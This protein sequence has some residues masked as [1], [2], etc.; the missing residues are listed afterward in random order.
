MNELTRRDFVRG[1]WTAGVGIG[2]A[3]ELLRSTL[4]RQA[5]APAPGT[6]PYA[7]VDPELLDA[8][9]KF[10]TPT[11]HSAPRRAGRSCPR[12]P[13]LRQTSPRPFER[14]ILDRPGPRH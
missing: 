12:V 10:P 4:A 7:M 14:H 6:D 2:V 13:P 11:F 1:G 8:I 3:P 9:K 5:Q